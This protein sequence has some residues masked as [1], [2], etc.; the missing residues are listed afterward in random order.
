MGLELNN[1]KTNIFTIGNGSSTSV[2]PILVEIG[3]HFIEV[4]RNE[5]KRDYLGVKLPGVL[6]KRGGVILPSRIW[7]VWAKFHIFRNAL[8]DKHVNIKLR[9][10]LFDSVVLPFALY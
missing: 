6:V 4:V 7:S 5:D 2:T 1:S 3:N 10:R 8:L 9:L